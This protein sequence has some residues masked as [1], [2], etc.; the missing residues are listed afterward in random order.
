[1]ASKKRTRE[2]GIYG[3][4]IRH[5]VPRTLEQGGDGVCD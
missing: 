4:N 5:L 3:W 1:V 2:E